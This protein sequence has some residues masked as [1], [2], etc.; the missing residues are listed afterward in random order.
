[1]WPKEKHSAKG[2]GHALLLHIDR[3]R[4]E[5]APTVTADSLT[6]RPQVECLTLTFYIS[7]VGEVV[8]VRPPSKRRCG[9]Q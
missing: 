7:S 3:C 1:M 8:D 9:R 6:G 5:L 2:N 4:S